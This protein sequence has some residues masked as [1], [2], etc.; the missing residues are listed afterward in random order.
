MSTQPDGEKRT[1]IF[2]PGQGR[3][4]KMGRMRAVFV[5]DGDETDSRYSVSEWWLEPRT[6][7]PGAHSHAEDHIFYVLTGMLHLFVDGQWS[8]APRGSYAVIPGGVEHD[9]QNRSGEE[10]GFISINAPGGFEKMMP[11][12][13]AWFAQNPLGDAVGAQ[14][15]VESDGKL[16]S[17][18]APASTKTR[19]EAWKDEENGNVTLASLERRAEMKKSELAG[20][21]TRLLHVIDADTPE[22]AAAVHNIK[23]GLGGYTPKGEAQDCPKGCG[24]KYYPG[25]SGIC[26]NCGQIP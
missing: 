20:V 16:A 13:V 2:S 26:P 15:G 23:M 3:T 8:D 21:K 10:C 9:F 24:A 25:G 18:L 22:E 5:A 14:K 11:H 19:F 4:Y 6:A 12:L 1:M 17:P 7:G